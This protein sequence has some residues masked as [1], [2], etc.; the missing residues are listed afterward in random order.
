MIDNFEIINTL[1][2]F[3]RPNSFYFLQ[4]L[5]RKKENPDLKSNSV[6]VNN[7]YL[8]DKNDLY[9]LKDR[10]IEDCTKN[11]ARAYINLNV[12]DLEKVG[13]FTLNKI[14][15][16]I[17]KGDYK[18]IK[19]AYASTC[20]S[21]HSEENKRWVIDIDTH[22]RDYIN[23]VRREIEQLQS[24]IKNNQYKILAEVPTKNGFHIIT[25]PFRLDKFKQKFPE[26]E[27][28]KNNPTILFI[29]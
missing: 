8:Y 23:G 18:A 9:K 22:D 13:L 25:N 21:H 12:L 26:I 5:K 27:T 16:L 20:G 7:F 29:S 10:V 24:E 6:V 1:L 3:P 17:I 28:H 15:E 11:N 14:T 2:D 4:V 19:N